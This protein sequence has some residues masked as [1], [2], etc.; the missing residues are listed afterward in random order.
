MIPF[1]CGTN[2]RIIIPRFYKIF[3]EY[4]VERP[5]KIETKWKKFSVQIYHMSIIVQ[6]CAHIIILNYLDKERWERFERM[7]ICVDMEMREHR[8]FGIRMRGF[9]G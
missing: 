5:I 4:S 3:S 9:M 8:G 7:G 1:K 6:T 2:M